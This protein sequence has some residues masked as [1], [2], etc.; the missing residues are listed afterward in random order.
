MQLALGLEL[1]AILLSS[2]TLPSEKHRL[3]DILLGLVK[4]RLVDILL[5]LGLKGY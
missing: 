4:D 1:E 2:Y 5:D 3:V